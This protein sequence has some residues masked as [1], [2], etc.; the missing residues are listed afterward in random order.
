MYQN[1]KNFTLIV[2]FGVLIASI[3]IWITSANDLLFHYSG[4]T[5]NSFTFNYLGYWNY[6]IFV[7]SLVLILIFA[8]YTYVWIKED[9]KFITMTASESKQTFMKNIKALEKIARKHGSRYESILAEA[10]EKWKVR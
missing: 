7:I 3:I 8:Y 4:L 1:I 2:Y 6:W 9:R 10:K 5:E